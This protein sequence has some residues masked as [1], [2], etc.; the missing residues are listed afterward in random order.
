MNVSKRRILARQAHVK[1]RH[2]Q[3][4][5][6]FFVVGVIVVGGILL[7]IFA[8][9]RPPYTPEVTGGPRVQLEQTYFDY[10]DVQNNTRVQTVFRV[11]NIGDQPLILQGEPVVEV[12]EG[13]CPPRAEVSTYT[14]NPGEEATIT[15][16]FS[17]HEGMDGQ[18]EF[19]VHL[20]TNDP[21]QSEIPLIVRSNW[22]V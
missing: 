8:N 20:L 21:T 18:H 7:S 17:M 22:V 14:L 1:V 6:V 10:G 2:Q 11:Q 13:C 4:K 5:N 15:L 3:W 19:R 9:Q 12:V 16:N